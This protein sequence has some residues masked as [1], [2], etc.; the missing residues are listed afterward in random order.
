[1]IYNITT[2]DAAHSKVAWPMPELQNKK[3]VRK[4]ARNLANPQPLSKML[5][6][7]LLTYN[8]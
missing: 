1:M 3:L 8:G 5:K 4:V 6:N 2:V 7:F